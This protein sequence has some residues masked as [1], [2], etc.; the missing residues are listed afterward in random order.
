MV[1]WVYESFRVFVEHTDWKRLE[2]RAQVFILFKVKSKTQRNNMQ[3][4]TNKKAEQKCSSSLY[5]EFDWNQRKQGGE[6]KRST[7]FDGFYQIT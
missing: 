1:K 5:L 7:Y 2:S 6:H 4:I 3:G